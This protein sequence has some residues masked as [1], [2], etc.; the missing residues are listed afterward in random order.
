M[1]RLAPD[2]MVDELQGW[3]SRACRTIR[4][5]P[6]FA[7]DV[8]TICKLNLKKPIYTPKTNENT[9]MIDD[10][11]TIRGY[12]YRIEIEPNRITLTP[13]KNLP[14]SDIEEVDA[15]LSVC[16]HCLSTRSQ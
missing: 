11:Y 2:A 10:S 3:D 15:S 8:G 12:Y 5:I 14:D 4:R 7:E 16:P 9:A 1:T 6:V 13:L